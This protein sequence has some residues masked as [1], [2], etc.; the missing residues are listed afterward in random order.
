MHLFRHLRASATIAGLCLVGLLSS[1]GET[2]PTPPPGPEGTAPPATLGLAGTWGDTEGY[3]QICDYVEPS[4][5]VYL[6]LDPLEGQKG[7]SGTFAMGVNNSGFIDGVISGEITESGEVRGEAR[8]SSSDERLEVALTWDGSHLVGTF[9]SREAITCDGLGAEGKLR[10]DVTLQKID[11]RPPPGTESPREPVE[12]DALEPNNGEGEAT[13]IQLDY[14]ADLVLQDE[15]WFKFTLSEEQLVTFEPSGEGYFFINATVYDA[16]MNRVDGFEFDNY[17]GSRGPNHVQLAA[18]TYYLKLSG[19]VESERRAYTLNVSSQTLPDAALE[20]NDTAQSATP[21]TLGAAAQEMYLANGDEDWF[22]FTLETAQIVT[23]TTTRGGDSFYYTLFDNEMNQYSSAYNSESLSATLPKGTYYLKVYGSYNTTLY[24]VS[25]SGKDLPDSAFEPNNSA[26]E[27]T[28][29]TF[30]ASGEVA[31]EMYLMQ[32]DE[33]WFTFTLNEARLVTF[34]LGESSYNFDAAL[35]NAGLEERRASTYYGAAFTAALEAGT[36]YLRVYD[37][38]YGN[39]SSYPLKLSSEPIPD[40][41]YEP[42][43]SFNAASAVTLPFSADAYMTQ[44]DEDWFSFTLTEEQLVTLERSDDNRN[45]SVA[46]RFYTEDGT[47]VGQQSFSLST[48]SPKSFIL[49]AD[50]Y[51]V[52]LSS[53]YYQNRDFAYSLSITSEAIP[54]LEYEPNNSRSDARTIALGFSD[55]DLLVSGD[56]EDWFCFT[57]EQATQVNITLTSG[58]YSHPDV[59]LR[60]ADGSYIRGLGSGSTSPVLSKGTYYLQ[61]DSYYYSGAK[62]Y[63]LSIAKK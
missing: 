45:D 30:D 53:S 42:N 33:D 57:L 35:Y 41:A 19:N 32:E 17:Y 48:D 2:T 43:N 63:G 6:Q 61:V 4:L 51:F 50:T 12:D 31:S 21:L 14:S 3:Y 24:S 1:C 62:K 49:P 37:Y 40:A 15:D 58:A 10:L 13:E 60:D 54:D 39:G 22:S 34:D 26:E 52:S 59:T 47:E 11:A 46:G 55:S 5:D 27:A 18:G 16:S 36:H 20:P 25:A 9:T 28:R 38:D 23:F 44:A 7:F 29:L 56:D 8:F